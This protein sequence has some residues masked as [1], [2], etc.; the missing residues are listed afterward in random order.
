MGLVIHCRLTDPKAV[1]GLLERP[2]GDAEE[3]QPFLDRAATGSLSDV[4][5]HRVHGRRELCSCSS[6]IVCRESFDHLQ[7]LL[8]Q[9]PGCL[10]EPESMSFPH[11]RTMA[12]CGTDASSKGPTT[13]D[14]PARRLGRNS[15]R[16]RRLLRSAAFS[17]P[18]P[19]P[20]RPFS[21]FRRSLR[22]AV[23]SVPLVS[24]FRR[25]LRSAVFSV[26]QV[27]PFR[28]SLRSAGFSVPLSSPFRCSLRSAV[29]S[30]PF[31]YHFLVDISVT[32][33][34]SPDL[35]TGQLLASKGR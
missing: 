8:G 28:C 4:R 13:C 20:F 19:S 30:V 9:L 33:P 12:A 32:G 26:P 3:L 5:A 34:T 21:P 6:R 31:C 16:T 18:P 29:L 35:L 23:L 2:T 7:G 17:V 27:S 11:A 24:P 15:S 10:E 22:S 25:F 1:L 14:C